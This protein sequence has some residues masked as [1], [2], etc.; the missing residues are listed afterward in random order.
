M[1][2]MK[3]TI[4]ILVAVTVCIASVLTAN[5]SG[6]YFLSEGI[7]YG[8]QNDEAYVHGY[9]G[10]GWDIVIREQFLNKYNVT[11]IEDYAF[12]ED[13]YIENLSFYEA[14]YLRKLGEYSFARCTNLGRADITSS[15]QELGAGV[16]DSC[17]ALNYL[18]FQ[19]DAAADI[20]RQF[21]YGCTSLET[22]VFL[23]EPVS[24][25]TLAF[26]NCSALS[27]LEIPDSVTQIAEN[28]FEGCDNLVICC[29]KDSY[30][31]QFAVENGIA[32]VITD[33][34]PASYI[35]G[36]ADGDGKLTIL[37]ATAIQRTLAALPV[38][39]F[40]EKAAD[41]NGNGLDILDATGIQRYLVGFS[42]P[43]HIGERITEN[44]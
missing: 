12:F 7:Y 13:V 22:V 2:N 23:N 27:R 24:I 6:T 40:H 9:D 25:G 31:L 43:Y 34:E 19:K 38:K 36:D 17:T 30:A 20:P 21:C 8:V 29:T 10:D 4:A 14:S 28:A 41:V 35:K 18:R 11:E 3:R 15:I 39:S 32:Y 1:I 16:F 44:N 42:D 37:D 33:A 5:A 26:A